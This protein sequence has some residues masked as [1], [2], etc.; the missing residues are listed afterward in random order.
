MASIEP[1]KDKNENYDGNKVTGLPAVKH[2]EPSMAKPE[3]VQ[4]KLNMKTDVILRVVPPFQ[5]E[6]VSS[7]SLPN[8]LDPADRGIDTNEKSSLLRD[9]PCKFEYTQWS[10]C[11]ATCYNGVNLPRKSRTVI[12][13]S[14][15][16][17]R[18]KYE[19]CPPDLIHKVDV[20]PCNTYKCPVLLSSFPFR[21]ECYFH[22]KVNGTENSCYQIRDVPLEDTLIMI[23]A[24]LIKQCYSCSDD[25][26]EI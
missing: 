7:E 13:D 18:G 1:I 24:D 12:K 15:I 17:S 19:P 21:K 22:S 14:I 16:R 2:E 4:Q 20:A 10:S 6:N 23:D 3:L 26:L 9:F 25:V 8:E 5:S 11:S